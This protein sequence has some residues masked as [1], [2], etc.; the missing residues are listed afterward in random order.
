MFTAVRKVARNDLSA[1]MAE[2][3]V[4]PSAGITRGHESRVRQMTRG[5]NI[6][7]PGQYLC[8]LRDDPRYRPT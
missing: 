2:A 8:R 5:G 6:I 4:A 7:Q 3:R 1:V